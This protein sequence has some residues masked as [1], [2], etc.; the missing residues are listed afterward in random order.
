MRR[1]NRP[2]LLF[3]RFVTM[4]I[5][6][7]TENTSKSTALSVFFCSFILKHIYELLIGLSGHMGGMIH[8]P[9]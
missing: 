3:H 9:C 6:M 8:A 4:I 7:H 2:T 1:L 5:K